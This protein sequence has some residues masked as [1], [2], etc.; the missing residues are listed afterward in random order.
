MDP[1]FRI[2]PLAF[3]FLPEIDR[4]ND[5]NTLACNP[6]NGELLKINPIG[7]F[8]LRTINDLP[9]L[10]FDQLISQL[11][12]IPSTKSCSLKYMKNFLN[13]MLSNNIIVLEY[14]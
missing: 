1:G 12:Q 8:I 3:L 10:K 9:L 4:E 5:Y 11:K 13:N 2:N 6:K 7:Y 14:P